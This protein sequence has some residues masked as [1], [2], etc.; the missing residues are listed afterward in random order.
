MPLDIIFSVCLEWCLVK[1]HLREL[2]LQE[3]PMRLNGQLE[4]E[5]AV[6]GRNDLRLN[7]KVAAGLTARPEAGTAYVSGMLTA[8]V[9]IECSRCLRTVRTRIQYPVEERFTPFRDVSE[10]DEDVHFV[11]DA[12]VD[13][14]PYLLEAFVVQ[15]PMAAVCSDACKG[16]CPSCGQD[17]NV[18]SCGCSAE[19][20]DPRLAGLQNYFNP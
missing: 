7:G 8:D 1:F 19:A 20:I 9:E 11:Q 13:L 5:R 2:L 17:R 15:L 16:L 3:A 14:Q 12:V 18:G 4:M 6:S 10:R